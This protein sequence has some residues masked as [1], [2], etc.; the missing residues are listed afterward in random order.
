MNSF[1]IA[2]TN[3]GCG[4]TTITIGLMHLLK[5]QGL[6]VAPFKIGPD[7]IDPRF[8]EKV[9]NTPSYNLDSYML[10]DE[11]LQYLF[12][13]HSKNADIAIA[14]GVMGLYDGLG[15]DS[16][17]STF[18]TATKLSLP[19]IL[20][21][22]C[23][24]LYQS[25]AAIINGF[26]SFH[27]ETNITGVLLN[28]V[29]GEKQ[30]HILKEY[31]EEHCPVKCIGYVPPIKNIALESRHLGL[32]QAEE[33]DQLSEKI[34]LL[35]DTLKQTINIDLLLK[36]TQSETIVPTQFQTSIPADY[37]KGV[38][39]GIA[40][41]KA[42]SFYYPDNI[43]LLEHHGAELIYFSPLESSSI[44]KECNALYFGGGYPEVFAEQLSSNTSLLQSIRKAADNHMPIFAECGGLM[45]LTDNIIQTDGKRFPMCGIFPCDT[46]VTN[47]LKRFGYAE[48]ELQGQQTRCHEFHRS[49][50]VNGNNEI[51]H[52]YQLSKPLSNQKWECG[53]RYKNVLAGYAHIHF[54]SDFD[55]TK[56]IFDLW[57]KAI[58]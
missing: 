14:E 39:L 42:F 18:E 37:L 17:G 53:L 4:K 20:V 36:C 54:W 38:K 25:V 57:R 8:H 45:F 19:I 16:I 33:V 11:T 9:L 13:Q 43:E 49:E 23:K 21:V 24:G 15:K 34:T 44:P 35:A 6:N 26:C 10:N 3:S 30:F 28:H 27:K 22:N 32:I 29:S 7:F 50:L 48:L 58:I 51:P 41:D 31:I 1:V 2:G 46:Q 56:Q 47:R 5:E 52:Q 12:H 40:K 55:F